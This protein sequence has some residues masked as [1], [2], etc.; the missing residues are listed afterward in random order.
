MDEQ[1]FKR[2]ARATGDSVKEAVQT[3]GGTVKKIHIFVTVA[4]VLYGLFVSWK[5]THAE[6]DNR[7]QAWVFVSQT[8]MGTSQ[9]GIFWNLLTL[10]FV[11]IIIAAV[12]PV[13]LKFGQKIKYII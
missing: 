10:W 3:Y 12:Y 1:T 7:R 9:N 2:V 6:T 11:T 13:V 5:V 8:W 4:L